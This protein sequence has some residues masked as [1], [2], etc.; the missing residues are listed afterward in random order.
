M[1]SKP[2]VP[3]ARLLRFRFR[4]R[5]GILLLQQVPTATNDHSH[6]VI[7]GFPLQDGLVQSHPVRQH[8]SIASNDILDV[9]SR[10]IH[11]NGIGN[12]DALFHDN[13]DFALHGNGE[14]RVA[15]Q[16]GRIFLVNVF[17]TELQHGP[18][19]V[20]GRV[21]DAKTINALDGMPIDIFGHH[22]SLI[23]GFLMV[24]V[25]FQTSIVFFHLLRLVPLG[26]R[27]GRFFVQA[28][29]V[30]ASA[31]D[32]IQIPIEF[33]LQDR[34]GCFDE[35]MTGIVVGLPRCRQMLRV[36]MTRGRKDAGNVT[37][38]RLLFAH[39]LGGI[40]F[41][42]HRRRPQVGLER[43]HIEGCIVQGVPFFLGH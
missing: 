8:E 40:L 3:L 4:R 1:L 42:F 36:G 6:D 30:H 43:T 39:P 14:T 32:A 29:I 35:Q 10:T 28:Q 19:G 27:R 34:P 22:E 20:V 26:R 15:P 17:H 23:K 5:T 12:T 25:R 41:A 11:F 7:L 18:T 9:Q 16:G 38:V 13:V 21:V 37:N 33:A 24:V 31:I 2:T